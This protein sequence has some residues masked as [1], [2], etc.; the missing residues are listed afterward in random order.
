MEKTIKGFK[1]NNRTQ[2]SF[3]KQFFCITSGWKEIWQGLLDI[4]FFPPVNVNLVKDINHHINTL[5][6]LT[7]IPH[8][9][10]KNQGSFP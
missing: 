7:K 6:S 1:N 8:F 4:P 10:T 5:A 2:M 3:Y 9:L